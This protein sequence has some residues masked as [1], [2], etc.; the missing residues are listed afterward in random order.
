M[1][2]FVR[3]NSPVVGVIKKAAFAQV[4]FSFWFIS[5]FYLYMGVV[6]GKGI[7]GGID[8]MK[9]KFMPTMMGH[10]KFWPFIQ[11]INFSVCP[12]KY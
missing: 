4:I 8:E 5:T 10:Y 6:N 1:P 2:Y 11:L 9:V 7:K 3:D 12:A